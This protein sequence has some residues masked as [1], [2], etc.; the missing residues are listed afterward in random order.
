MCLRKDLGLEKLH[1]AV[2][3]AGTAVF[4]DA[5]IGIGIEEGRVA[6][7]IDTRGFLGFFLGL[8]HV[9][10]HGCSVDIDGSVAHELF[11]FG[12]NFLAVGAPVGI[13]H[14]E[15][16]SSIGCIGSRVGFEPLHHARTS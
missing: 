16:V 15:G 2:R 11:E 3:S 1:E 14:D 12:F 10:M 9:D 8:D 7:D 6:F 13:V 5:A 4:D